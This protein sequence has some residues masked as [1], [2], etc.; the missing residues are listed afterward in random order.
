MIY[1]GGNMD[2]LGKLS[3]IG[4]RAAFALMIMGSIVLSLAAQTIAPQQQGKRFGDPEIGRAH[5]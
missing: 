1:N 4:K 5:V 3:V 2:S